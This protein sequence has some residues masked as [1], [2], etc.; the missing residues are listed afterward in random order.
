MDSTLEKRHL[1]LM[2]AL[3]E[4]RYLRSQVIGKRCDSNCYDYECHSKRICKMLASDEIVQRIDRALAEDRR[5]KN[6]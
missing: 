5:L 3:V 4:V 6:E 1:A 2:T